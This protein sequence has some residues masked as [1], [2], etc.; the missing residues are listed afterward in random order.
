L[1]ARERSFMQVAG[2]P[3]RDAVVQSVLIAQAWHVSASAAYMMQR[4]L[5]DSC[6]RTRVSPLGSGRCPFSRRNGTAAVN[7]VPSPL[8]LTE[9]LA[10]TCGTMPCRCCC[11]HRFGCSRWSNRRRQPRGESRC[12]DPWLAAWPWQQAAVV[13]R[14][15]GHLLGHDQRM[16]GIQAVCTL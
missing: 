12:N 13:G 3:G 1:H 8:L 16:F 2:N 15:R 9:R 4:S 10:G 6:M 7:S 11:S 5:R 14:L